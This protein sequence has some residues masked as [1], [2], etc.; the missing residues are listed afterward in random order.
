[1]NEQMNDRKK[2][3]KSLNTGR[4]MKELKKEMKKREQIEIN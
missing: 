2:S 3:D 4:K 1:M